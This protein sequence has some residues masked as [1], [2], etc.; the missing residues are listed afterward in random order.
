MQLIRRLGLMAAAT[1]LVIATVGVP[2]SAATYGNTVA[3]VNGI[4]G[5]RIDLCIDGKEIRSGLRYG[6]RV[7]RD[8]G[9]G[10]KKLKVFAKH[11]GQCRGTKLA[12]KRFTQE[13][14]GDLTIVVTR[15]DPKVLIFD[16]TDLGAIETT[17]SA[18]LPA[19]VAWRHAA[20]LGTVWFQSRTVSP[21]S[22]EQP[23]LAAATDWSKGQ[24]R[25][26]L[27]PSGAGMLVQVTRPA[28]T[29]IIA[30]AP[31]VD[32]EAFTRYEW[33][34]VGTTAKNAKLVSFKRPVTILI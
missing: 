9:P 28:R 3:I 13:P 16:N 19:A 14:G 32:I 34:L 15:K 26:V 11:A 33:I 31:V 27:E 8:L 23:T 10:A 1:A 6:G 2:V 17:P 21:V 12:Q 25:T 4:P 22:I 24:Q 30:E 5:K 29:K 18:G 20:D 7:F